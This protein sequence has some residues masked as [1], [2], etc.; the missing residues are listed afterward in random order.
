MP[1]IKYLVV[2]ANHLDQ[3][4]L[5]RYGADGWRLATEEQQATTRKYTFWREIEDS[6]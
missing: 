3:A 4:D 6:A 1:R 2:H 5:D